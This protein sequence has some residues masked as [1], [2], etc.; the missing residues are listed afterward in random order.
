M[1]TELFGFL[2]QSKLSGACLINDSTEAVKT[3]G[4]SGIPKL[5]GDSLSDNV[6]LS[7]L[8]GFISSSEF[9]ECLLVFITWCF[10]TFEL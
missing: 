7:S 10:F 9:F 5:L 3:V 4:L 1:L 2:G 8:S 6:G